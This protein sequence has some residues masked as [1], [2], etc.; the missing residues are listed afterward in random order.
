M[1]RQLLKDKVA[2]VVGASYGMGT[3]M[4][5]MYAEE[6]AKLV[7]TSRGKEKLDEEVEKIK[8]MGYPDVVGVVA[9]SEKLE[10]VQN[11]FKVALDTFGDV[12]IVLNN[13]GLGEQMII[14]ETTDEWAMHVLNTNVVGP[15]RYIREAL[16]IF[17]PKNE[18]RIILVSSVNGTRPH[19][20]A[21]YTSSK[22]AL[23]T[24]VRNVAIR[25]VDTNIRINA[26][27]PGATRTEIHLA[28]IDN[29]K[30]DPEQIPMQKYAKHFVYFPGP[31]CECEDQAYAAV[32][33]ASKMGR[34]VQG[35]VLQV[36]NG[37]YL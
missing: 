14:D 10:D 6:G 23:N 20:G 16:K 36:C 37:A 19:C 27:A 30:N 3:A 26:I 29:I 7:L 21:A 24:L 11:V 12:D 9:D 4:A 13:A 2:I 22:G 25:C 1:E 17:L 5:E 31:E 8:A 18:G 33:L 28:N 15:M 34:A 35:Q 32:F